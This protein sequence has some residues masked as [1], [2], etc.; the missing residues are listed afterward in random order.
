MQ[1]VGVRSNS[2]RE[3]HRSPIAIEPPRELHQISTVYVNKFVAATLS[4]HSRRA[5]THTESPPS[6]PDLH[7]R[8]RNTCC[9]SQP[10]RCRAGVRIFLWCRP[11]ATP[12]IGQH[13]LD[14]NRAWALRIRGRVYRE[15]RGDTRGNFCSAMFGS[16]GKPRR[17]EV[18][19][20]FACPVIRATLLP[21]VSYPSPST[22]N[23]RPAPGH[24]HSR[25]A[26]LANHLHR[27]P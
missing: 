12:Q 25:P 18:G 26:P 6:F 27:P 17:T 3:S 11:F 24:P 8:P 5:H 15:P 7:N 14:R 4:R 20:R 10:G 16:T 19:Q 1:P 23:S 2:I 21:H 9:R 13:V 22:L